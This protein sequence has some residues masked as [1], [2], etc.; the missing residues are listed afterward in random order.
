MYVCMCH[1][2]PVEVRGQL[3]HVGVLLYMKVLAVEL[4]LSGLVAY[5]INHLTNSKLFFKK[6]YIYVYIFICVSISVWVPMEDRKRDWIR[7]S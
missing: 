2:V 3:S 6:I 7:W 1:G 4:R 5:P